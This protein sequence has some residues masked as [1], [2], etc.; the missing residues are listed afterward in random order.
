MAENYPKRRSDVNVRVME[1][2]TVVLDRQ[3]EL[4]HHL[5]QTASYIWDRCDGMSP[6]AEIANQLAEA[7]DVD[8]KIAAKDVAVI[9]LQLRGLNLLEPH[10][11][12]TLLS[13]P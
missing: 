1:G 12:F 13:E 7:F 11:E 2:E 10:R 8:P 4:I 3:G 5:N 6:L 9:V